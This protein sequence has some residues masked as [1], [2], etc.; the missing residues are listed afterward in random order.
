MFLNLALE[1]YSDGVYLFD[2][3]DIARDLWDRNFYIINPRGN[4]VH[5]HHRASSVIHDNIVE[6]LTN[7]FNSPGQISSWPLRDSF[8]D[9]INERRHSRWL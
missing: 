4:G 2:S 7:L 3:W 5:I 6:N 8:R 9:I 1:F